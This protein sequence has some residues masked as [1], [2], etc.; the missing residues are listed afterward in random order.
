MDLCIQKR[1]LLYI[2]FIYTSLTLDARAVETT[3][4]FLNK[5]HGSLRTNG[6]FYLI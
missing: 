1:K 6:M 3:K 4:L 5:E 2:L